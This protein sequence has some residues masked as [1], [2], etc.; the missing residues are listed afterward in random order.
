MD[1]GGSPQ[2]GIVILLLLV[3]LHIVFYGFLAALSGLN[4]NDLE[5]LADVGDKR[6]SLLLRL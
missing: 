6:A 4:G 3:V 5:K 1:D 2:I